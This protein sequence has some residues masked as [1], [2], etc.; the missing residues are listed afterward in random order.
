MSEF[1]Y[2]LNFY[3]E[4]GL[5]RQCATLDRSSIINMLWSQLGEPEEDDGMQFQVIKLFREE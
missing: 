1:V 2:L 5:E 3:E 4:H